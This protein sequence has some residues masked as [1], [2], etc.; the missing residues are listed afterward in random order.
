MGD[1]KKFYIGNREKPL[2]DTRVYKKKISNC[3]ECPLMDKMRQE[4]RRTVYEM[5]RCL[6]LKKVLNSPWSSVDPDCPLDKK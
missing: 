1:K 4:H 3:I 2:K 5:H 6:E